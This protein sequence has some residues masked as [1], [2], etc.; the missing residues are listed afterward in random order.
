MGETAIIMSK[1]TLQH[2]ERIPTGTNGESKW[3]YLQ[4][5]CS[6]QR[7]LQFPADGQIKTE[8]L[9][10]AMIILQRLKYTVWRG[11][12]IQANKEVFLNFKTD[13][14]HACAKHNKPKT[15][16]NVLHKGKTPSKLR[17][18]AI[19]YVYQD[20]KLIVI[21][22]FTISI[23]NWKKPAETRLSWVPGLSWYPSL[24]LAGQ[25]SFSWSG[26]PA[27]PP[28]KH[29]L[30]Q[31]RRSTCPISP[32]LTCCLDQLITAT[33]I[34]NQVRSANQLDQAGQASGVQLV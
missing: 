6:G 1:E 20:V 7:N 4:E 17:G 18:G 24:V 10:E 16:L 8:M 29:R 12:K 11:V 13:W 9:K 33:S 32:A 5:L 15:F 34:L 22:T 23:P 2:W 26:W 31:A 27:D 14:V 19:K 30:E 28:S 3:S 25:V 21:L